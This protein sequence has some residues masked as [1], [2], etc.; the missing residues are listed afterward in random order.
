MIKVT[1]QK[2][3]LVTTKTQ[4]LTFSYSQ[5]FKWLAE[6]NISSFLF[7]PSDKENEA[8][9]SQRCKKVKKAG[10][11]VTESNEMHHFMTA[12]AI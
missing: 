11:V 9:V 7:R 10:F 4:A 3:V 5:F 6:N 1:M 8:L 12:I 2:N